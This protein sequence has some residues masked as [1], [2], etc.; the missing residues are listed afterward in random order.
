M[1]A[2]FL[3]VILGLV[4]LWGAR[5]WMRLRRQVNAWPVVRGHV[6][7]RHA[8][9]PTDRGRTSTPAFRWAPDVRFSYRVDDT[10]YIGEKILAAL[11]LDAYQGLGRGLP[12]H[13]P[14][15]GG[16]PLRSDRSPDELPLPAPLRKRP[17]VRHPGSGVARRRRAH[18]AG[19]GRRGTP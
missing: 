11:E 15:R 17:L 8:I 13:D 16:C 3:L 6:T 7:A 2:G 5:Y 12:G 18:P 19:A 9:Q 1:L 14:R 4:S 10:D